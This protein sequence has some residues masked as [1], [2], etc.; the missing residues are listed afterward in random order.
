DAIRETLGIVDRELDV[1]GRDGVDQAR[2]VLQVAEDHR[3]VVAP[4]G[5]GVDA[6]G[7]G[8]QAR[9]DGVADGLGEGLVVGD[10]DR[11]GGGVVFG[12][13]EQVGG[14]PVGIVVGVGHD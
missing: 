1:L 14:D 7:Q 5:G 4:R 3:A 12:L 2:A 6:G 13:A 8:R 9:V 10:Q 11:L